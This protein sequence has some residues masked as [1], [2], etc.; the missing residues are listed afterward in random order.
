M[1]VLVGRL[2]QFLRLLTEQM[3]G[4]E[5][6]TIK[7]KPSTPESREGH[8]RIWGSTKRTFL[9]RYGEEVPADSPSMASLLETTTFDTKADAMQ[10][11]A[12]MK[13]WLDE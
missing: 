3:E 6:M 11:I 9:D 13:G 10:F 7:S 8:E 2:Y 12:K 4:V 5:P 1:V